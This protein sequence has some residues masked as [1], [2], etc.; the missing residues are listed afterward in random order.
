MILPPIAGEQP[1]FGVW[2]IGL[3]LGAAGLFF[4]ALFHVLPKANAVPVK[5]PFLIESLTYHN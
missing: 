1:V 3:M 2:E 4:L 5:D